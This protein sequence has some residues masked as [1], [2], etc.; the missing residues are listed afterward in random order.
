[1]FPCLETIVSE[2][3]LLSLTVGLWSRN[4]FVAPAVA[5]IAQLVISFLV[6]DADALRDH[7]LF[8]M[9]VWAGSAGGYLASLGLNERTLIR[10]GRRVRLVHTLGNILL[11]LVILLLDLSYLP[12]RYYINNTWGI[13][14]GAIALLC[15]VGVHHFISMVLWKRLPARDSYMSTKK[16]VMKF[17]RVS[18]GLQIFGI[19]SMI[20]ADV[21][22]ND[23]DIVLVIHFLAM[24][25]AATASCIW[26]ICTEARHR[27]RHMPVHTQWH[28]NIPSL[29]D[30]DT[31]STSSDTEKSYVEY[32]TQ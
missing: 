2:G 28:A 1:M 16:R 21:L 25:V 29:G 6:T 12:I 27:R 20:L 4:A 11:L 26:C 18:F 30:T 17:T 14:V 9:A 23:S 8:A 7:S 5:S 31:L 19:S 32:H 24:A 10:C 13:A 15:S 3:F 22:P